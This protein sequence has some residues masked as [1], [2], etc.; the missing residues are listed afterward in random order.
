MK[1]FNLSEAIGANKE[2]TFVLWNPKVYY[3]FIEIPTGHYPK[4]L[5]PS[6]RTYTLIL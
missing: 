4:I 2:V 3:L 5:K 1:M 6:P